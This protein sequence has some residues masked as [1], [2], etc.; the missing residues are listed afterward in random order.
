[1]ATVSQAAIEAGLSELAVYQLLDAGDL[2]F[3]EDSEGHVLVCLNSLSEERAR[4][5]RLKKQ[6]PQSP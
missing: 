6:V 1:M 5:T 2:H 4:S 3:T